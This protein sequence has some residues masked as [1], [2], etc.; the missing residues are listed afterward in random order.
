MD[1][2]SH[3]SIDQ[4]AL[5]CQH[6]LRACLGLVLF[7]GGMLGRFAIGKVKK[8]DECV[9]RVDRI[10]LRCEERASCRKRLK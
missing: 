3:L 1:I 8:W 10:E 5:L 9:R 6:V 4:M 7:M 2:F